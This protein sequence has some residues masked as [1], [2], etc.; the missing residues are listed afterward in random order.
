MRLFV[1]NLLSGKLKMRCSELAKERYTHRS[2]IA[3]TAVIIPVWI[4]ILVSFDTKSSTFVWPVRCFLRYMTSAM[5]MTESVTA[6]RTSHTM[7]TDLNF[8]NCTKKRTIE[9]PIV[10]PV[11][12]RSWT[13]AEIM[14]RA[15]SHVCFV[16]RLIRH[17]KKV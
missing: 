14:I 12:H 10:V 9:Q 11:P 15:A 2:T 1:Y 5:A 17:A 3:Q 16:K 6:E 7:T 13:N 4:T 8:W